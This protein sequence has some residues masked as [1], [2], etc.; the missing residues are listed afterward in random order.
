MRNE[1]AVRVGAQGFWVLGDE[2]RAEHLGEVSVGDQRI[3]L[4]RW[5]GAGEINQVALPIPP[6][7]AFDIRRRV[8]TNTFRSAEMTF[9]IQLFIGDPNNNSSNAQQ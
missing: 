7:V 2:L 8:Q 9:Q 5:E 6:N 4:H 3:R 1:P